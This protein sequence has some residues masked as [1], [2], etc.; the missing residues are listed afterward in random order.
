MDGPAAGIFGEKRFRRHGRDQIAKGYAGL[1]ILHRTTLL[2][3]A[4]QTLFWPLSP[5][6]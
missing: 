2:V 4:F 6:P 3:P 1:R 5:R